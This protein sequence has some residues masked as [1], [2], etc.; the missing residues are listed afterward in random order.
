MFLLAEDSKESIN[1]II[2]GEVWEFAKQ[3]PAFLLFIFLSVLM[4]QVWI[5]LC[6]TFYLSSTKGKDVINSWIGRLAIGGVPTAIVIFIYHMI[7]NRQTVVD[8][9]T[10]LINS[11]TIG[12]FITLV[13][14]VL[15]VIVTFTV[16]YIKTS[17]KKAKKERT[18][19][20]E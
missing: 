16:S 18:V 10:P 12:T 11:I 9:P 2:L 19:K 6:Y 7:V 8:N 14:Q 15:L 3:S 17:R 4:G 5:F 20:D 1:D 13:L